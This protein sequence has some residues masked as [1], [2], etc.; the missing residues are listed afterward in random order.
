M[1]LPFP[2][3]VFC[4]CK[5]KRLERIIEEKPA[6]VVECRRDFVDTNIHT[7]MFIHDNIESEIFPRSKLKSHRAIFA[8]EIA[9]CCICWGMEST[10]L[11]LPK[12]LIKFKLFFCDIDTDGFIN[13]E[14]PS[15][16][17]IVNR[18]LFN[19]HHYTW[20]TNL[21]TMNQRFSIAISALYS[22]WN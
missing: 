17:V 21:F 8:C 15:K 3:S 12:N 22:K 5:E 11:W 2:L 7:L 6:H 10:L 9:F 13:F 16:N 4:R 20:K 18:R 14:P 1:S 19:H